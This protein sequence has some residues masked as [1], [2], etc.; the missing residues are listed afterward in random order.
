MKCVMCLQ[1]TGSGSGGIAGEDASSHNKDTGREIGIVV[2]I[3]VVILIII[4]GEL[5][6]LLS[7]QF[8]HF[9]L[10]NSHSDCCSSVLQITRQ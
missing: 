7:Y 10:S 9:N 4:A 6:Q 2:G 8:I 5:G 3:A 1:I